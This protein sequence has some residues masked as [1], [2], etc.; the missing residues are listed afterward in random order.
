MSNEKG[1]TVL[2]EA[3][4][5]ISTD[6]NHSYGHC[7]DDYSK[8]AGMVS[9]LLAGKLKEPLTAEDAVLFMVCVKISREVHLHKR[10]NVVDGCGYFAL[11]QEIKD[12]RERRSLK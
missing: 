3:Q 4:R 11:I 8:V 1:E 5:L 10:D 9:A 7:L 2:Q 6:R 12:E